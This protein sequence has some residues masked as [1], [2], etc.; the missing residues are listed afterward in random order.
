MGTH[1]ESCWVSDSEINLALLKKKKKIA[2]ENKTKD[3]FWGKLTKEPGCPGTLAPQP[4]SPHSRANPR[5]VSR[6]DHP[7]IEGGSKRGAQ[8]Q[9]LC[10]RSA[11]VGGSLQS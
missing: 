3:N 11:G 10:D 5:M 7:K 1:W 8:H 6:G 4:H 2:T 9:K